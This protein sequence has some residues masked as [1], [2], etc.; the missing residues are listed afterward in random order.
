MLG[1]WQ[2]MLTWRFPHRA[3]VEWQW[4]GSVIG[5]M[6]NDSHAEQL[7]H[8]G[9]EAFGLR[10]CC[11]SCPGMV[12]SPAT[13][14]RRMKQTSQQSSALR[15]ICSACLSAR[16]KSH[17]SGFSGE[18]ALGSRSAISPALFCVMRTLQSCPFSG[19][20]LLARSDRWESFVREAL[21]DGRGSHTHDTPCCEQMFHV[22]RC[23]LALH[24]LIAAAMSRMLRRQQELSEAT[25]GFNEAAS[26]LDRAGSRNSAFLGV[27][28]A[29]S[30]D[31]AQHTDG[32]QMVVRGYSD[33][34]HSQAKLVDSAAAAM[35]EVKHPNIL[36][37]IGVCP[38]S[39]SA[40]YRLM[41]VSNILIYLTPRHHCQGNRTISLFQVLAIHVRKSVFWLLSH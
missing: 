14:L 20:L 41:E 33:I 7:S 16:L 38:N 9:M 3:A 40:V 25:D 8:H 18:C 10:Q 1:A 32:M 35:A 30:R 36:P 5:K 31:A 15:A 28:P 12:S 27:L 11:K 2:P 26:R 19:S 4:K 24:L 39:G 23:K 21:F 13:T 29:T 17:P 22:I 37:L 6:I 34:C